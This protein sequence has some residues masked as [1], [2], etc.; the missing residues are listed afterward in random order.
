MTR[1]TR[2]RRRSS[3]FHFHARHVRQAGL[4]AAIIAVSTVV[5]CRGD[6]ITNPRQVPAP[7]FDV[8][9][10]SETTPIFMDDPCTEELVSG[11]YQNRM[12]IS[13]DFSH[14]N[15]H[16]HITFSGTGIDRLTGLPKPTRY[17]G[18]EEDMFVVNTPFLDKFEL[19][20][21][22]NMRI[23][24]TNAP[25]GEAN[26]DFLF[27]LNNHITVTPPA[28]ITAFIDNVSVDCK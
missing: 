13:S 8:S 10:P 4:A 26:D 1:Q 21:V 19:T 9:A 25:L 22:I 16:G 5:G 23:Y 11:T 12:T 20:D 28:G 7:Q 17:T 24:A 18:S 15:L 2:N 6:R 3:S 27:H 14:F